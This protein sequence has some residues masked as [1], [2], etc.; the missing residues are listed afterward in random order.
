[1]TASHRALTRAGRPA[2][3]PGKARGAG[4]AKRLIRSA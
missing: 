4:W 1:M 2:V 3:T